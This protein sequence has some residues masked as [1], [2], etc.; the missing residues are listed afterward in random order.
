MTQLCENYNNLGKSNGNAMENPVSKTSNWLASSFLAGILIFGVGGAVVYGLEG[1]E[2]Y[3]PDELYVDE[4]GA[5][6]YAYPPGLLPASSWQRIMVGLEDHFEEN[7]ETDEE[8]VAYLSEYLT[9]NA[10]SEGAPSKLSMLL[11]NMPAEP[12]LRV[13]SLPGFEQA[14]ESELE[15]IEGLNVGMEFFSPCEDCHRQA[16]QGLFDKELLRG[17]YGPTSR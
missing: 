11:R 3:E 17:G 10:L 12:P 9:A 14:H 6:H 5:C 7:A 16:E 8:T 13:T 2:V 4:C 15:L 1:E